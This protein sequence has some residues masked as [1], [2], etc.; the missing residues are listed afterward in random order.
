MATGLG[1]SQNFFANRTS[2]EQPA[3]QVLRSGERLATTLAAAASEGHKTYY[4]RV[5]GAKTHLPD[6]LEIQF[7]G[8]VFMTADPQIQAHLDAVANRPGSGITTAR[9]SE[10]AL[11][12]AE[13]TAAADA[14]NTASKTPE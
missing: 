4:H 10:S 14:A 7:L 9:A 6:G 3:S 1:N 11:I 13:R 12:A 2:Q 8:G 5:A